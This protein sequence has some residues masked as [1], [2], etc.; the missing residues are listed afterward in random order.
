MIVISG[1]TSLSKMASISK[2]VLNHE[3]AVG[4]LA[5]A[6]QL[7]QSCGTQASGVVLL[8]SYKTYGGI[9]H[10]YH[11]MDLPLCMVTG[12]RGDGLDERKDIAFL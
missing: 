4:S 12:R 5:V 8:E 3:E 1:R 10:H 2:G 6:R 11:R 7:V 9:Y